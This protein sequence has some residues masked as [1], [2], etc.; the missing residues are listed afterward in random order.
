MARPKFLV[1]GTLERVKPNEYQG[2]VTGHT[3]VLVGMGWTE[4]IELHP[5]V[6]SEVERSV[7]KS[8]VLEFSCLAKTSKAGKGYL[9]TWG[10]RFPQKASQ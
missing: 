5:D 8:V 6:V 4:N 2:K 9:S 1:Q 3:A 10:G 7:G